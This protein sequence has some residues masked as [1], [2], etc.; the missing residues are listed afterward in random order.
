M[1]VDNVVVYMSCDGARVVA[2]MEDVRFLTEQLESGVNGGRDSLS[3]GETE[4]K[5]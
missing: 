3:R 4:E 1:M 5:G 2:C